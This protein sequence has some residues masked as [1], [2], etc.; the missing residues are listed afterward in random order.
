MTAL[1]KLTTT[2]LTLTLI[3]SMAHAE[4]ID[5]I[6]AVVEEQLITL[7]DVRGV[8]RLGLETVLKQTTR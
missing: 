8:I 5:R 3:A 4:I 7:S 1:L 2:I 6:L